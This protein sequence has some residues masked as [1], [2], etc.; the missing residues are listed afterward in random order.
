MF[1]KHKDHWYKEGNI[2]FLAGSEA[3]RLHESVL[4]RRSP[5][6][7]NL[8]SLPVPAPP[9][10]FEESDNRDVI[11]DG[12]PFVVLQ[13][14]AKDFANVLDFIYPNTLPAA[15]T[16]HLDVQDLMGMVRLAGKYFIEDLMEWAVSR[17]GKA[18]LLQL[19]NSEFKEALEDW[20]RYLDPHFCVQ[21]FQFSRECSLPQFLPL[22]FY[23]LAT[24]DWE[25]LP[26]DTACL[27]ELCS[28]DQFRVHKGR[29][30]LIKEVIREAFK[31]PENHGEA[32]K[33]RSWICSNPRPTM[34]TD[35]KKR[36]ENLML[37]PLEELEARLSFSYSSLCRECQTGLKR[38]T[39]ELRDQLVHNLTELFSLNGDDDS[40]SY[41]S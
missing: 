41:E 33:C 2:A 22:A 18:F 27:E 38:R 40:G 17:L 39:R 29:V 8:L 37:H 19:E 15:R 5:V 1:W 9:S 3:F 21:V 16:E 10:P 20:E 28:E 32:G 13:D 7:A 34:W 14:N 12:V 30:S 23:A 11:I 35:P 6:I 4:S 36:W 31:M 25:T 24:K 26:L